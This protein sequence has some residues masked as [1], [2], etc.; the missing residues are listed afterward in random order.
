[1]CYSELFSACYHSGASL[2]LRLPLGSHSRPSGQFLK[3][4]A[5]QA[6]NWE[7]VRWQASFTN[8]RADD[9]NTDALN[10]P[11]NSGAQ[12]HKSFVID[13][14][15]LP[16]VPLPRMPSNLGPPLSFSYSHSRRN[17]EI[18]AI[19]HQRRRQYFPDAD[20]LK[21]MHYFSSPSDQ[22]EECFSCEPYC[23]MN[24]VNEKNFPQNQQRGT[25]AA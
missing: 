20:D 1:M 2:C 23:V 15:I 24:K 3:T 9:A 12:G 8:E 17:C 4:A 5:E 7:L 10:C 6:N 13:C 16:S 21:T 11:R 18:K 25:H 19:W 22:G 14:L